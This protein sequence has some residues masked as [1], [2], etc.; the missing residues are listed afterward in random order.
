MTDMP[1]AKASAEISDAAVLNGTA[2]ELYYFAY[3]SNM[4]KEQISARC[5]KPKVIAV[6]RLADYRLAFFGYSATWDGGEETV[7]PA[8]GR[9]VWGVVYQ[10]SS[11]DRDRLDDAQDAR[12]D[13]SGSYFHFPAN[14]T[15]QDGKVYPVL[16]FKKDSLGSSQK[17]SQEYLNF[18]VE[19]AV[20][21]G[22]AG[23][24]VETLRTMESKKAAYVVPRQKK[25]A[26]E[27]TAVSDCSK[28]GDS[29]ATSPSSVVNISLG[30]GDNS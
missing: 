8:P 7:I 9:D 4:S 29:A 23:D 22:L 13:G 19:G 15:G 5:A 6:A 12:L 3:G 17:P 26:R 21:N 27:F 14:V 1:K 11:S 24:Y 10:L 20:S 30:S 25:S 18:I 28:C 2:D 16:L